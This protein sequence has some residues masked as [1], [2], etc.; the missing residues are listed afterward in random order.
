MPLRIMCNPDVGMRLIV[1]IFAASI[2]GGLS[3]IYGAFIGG[4]L[5]GFAEILGTGYLSLAVGTWVV[6]YRPI[7][8]LLMMAITLLFAPKGLTGIKWRI[9]RR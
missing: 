2:L 6:P 3:S 7:I 5:I 9:F 4:L 8:P 1:S